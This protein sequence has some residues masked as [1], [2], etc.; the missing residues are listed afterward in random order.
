MNRLIEF[1]IRY[2]HWFL[3]FILELIALLLL[4]NRSVHHSAIR[5]S[6]MNSIVGYSNDIA[7]KWYAYIDLKKENEALLIEKA[8]I[9]NRYLQLQKDF[10]TYKANNIS[11]L[12][13]IKQESNCEVLITAEVVNRRKIDNRSYII[14]NKGRNHGVRKNM[15]VIG[16]SGVIGCIMS[17]SDNYSIIIPIINNNFQLNCVSKQSGSSGTLVSYGLENFCS[18]KNIPKHIKLQIGDSILTGKDSYI[19]PEG[20][21]VGRISPNKQGTHYNVRLATNFNGLHNVYIIN[22]K[23]SSEINSLED[24]IKSND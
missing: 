10:E 1:I 19:F 12:D 2:K 14:I 22:K 5:S 3:F 6:M 4:F 23:K 15:G 9:E 17:T 16:R 21:L 8:N 7:N 13:S 24:Q 20:L 11:I 18:L